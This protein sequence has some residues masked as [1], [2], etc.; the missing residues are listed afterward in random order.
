[1]G[2]ALVFDIGGTTIRA[3]VLDRST[4]FLDTANRGATPNFQTHSELGASALLDRVI[5]KVAELASNLLGHDVPSVVVAG[6][7]GPVSPSGVAWRSPTILGPVLDCESDVKARLQERWPSA[8]I[9][10]L[11]DLSCAGYAYVAQG[12]RDFCVITVGSGIGNKVFLNGRPVIGKNGRGGEIGHLQVFPGQR[13]PRPA[14][15]DELGNI[16]SG[17]GN[18][19]LCRQFVDEY[20][21]EKSISTLLPASGGELS[22]NDGIQLARAFRMRDELAIRVVET[23]CFPLAQSIATIHLATGLE[24]FFIVGG[25]AKALGQEYLK[26]LI[27][28]ARKLTWDLGQD[29]EQMISMG[30]EA[31]EEVLVGAAHL[32]AAQS[33]EKIADLC[34]GVL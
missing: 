28:Y 5:D 31:V 11:N 14:A 18:I 22:P 25:F 2:V 33:T 32:V 15:R 9:S 1:M 4:G 7:P 29:W 23:A 24:S 21:E 27:R 3:G 17:R 6:Y 12:H 20:S 34:E 10:V 19:K 8:R 16:A 30:D 13:A 26:I